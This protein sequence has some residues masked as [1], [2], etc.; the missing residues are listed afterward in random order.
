[1]FQGEKFPKGR[2]NPAKEAYWCTRDKGSHE[3]HIFARIPIFSS[4]VGDVL[5]YRGK[6][7]EKSGKKRW[8]AH[9]EDREE[10]G[11]E[12]S[13]TPE[14]R[15]TA[16]AGEEQRATAEARGSENTDGACDREND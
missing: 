7:R 6:Q 15:Q 9:R 13:R 11:V 8:T 5:I 2:T 10:L 14:H 1:V 16:T 4:E 3:L 12:R